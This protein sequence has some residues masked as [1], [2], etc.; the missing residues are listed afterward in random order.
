MTGTEL[1]QRLWLLVPDINAY[2]KMIL[3]RIICKGTDAYESGELARI[4]LRHADQ[5]LRDPA[6]ERRAIPVDC[7]TR[8]AARLTD[9][10]TPG[11]QDGVG[12][13][14]LALVCDPEN[15][16]WLE[17]IGRLIEDY[18]DVF[19][20]DAAPVPEAVLY[21][22]SHLSGSWWHEGEVIRLRLGVRNCPACTPQPGDVVAEAEA[23]DGYR[24]VLRKPWDDALIWNWYGAEGHVYGGPFSAPKFAIYEREKAGWRITRY[25]PGWPVADVVPPAGPDPNAGSTAATDTERIGDCL[26]AGRLEPFAVPGEGVWRA[27][28]AGTNQDDHAQPAPEA[29]DLLGLIGDLADALVW[30]SGSS[31]FAPEGKAHKGWLKVAN[32]PLAEALNLTHLRFGTDTESAPPTLPREVWAGDTD[33]GRYRIVQNGVAGFLLQKEKAVQTWVP[34]EVMSFRGTSVIQALAARIVALQDAQ[35]VRHA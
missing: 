10:A 32:G 3:E 20:R 14:M 8:I 30:A 16:K 35:E 23:Q 24:I 25:P 34:V 21:P 4:I 22:C 9:L 6:P 29:V 13:G 28:D 27:L 1:A 33:D 7:Q 5:V 18:P 15:Q 11:I 26:G 12:R 31:D 19:L 17:D 2:D